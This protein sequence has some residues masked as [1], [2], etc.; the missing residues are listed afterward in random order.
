MAIKGRW[1]PWQPGSGGPGYLWINLRAD[2]A[3]RGFDVSD[4]TLHTM[5][6]TCATRLAVGGMDLLGLR[7]WLGHSDIKITAERYIHLMSSHLYQGAA[8]LNLS[9]GAPSPTEGIEHEDDAPCAMHDTLA[10]GRE[11]ANA[12]APS[13]Q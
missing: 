7:D 3:E 6:H 1:F 2:M 4:V 5:R 11:Y 12:G 10:S 8:I 13:L 9:A